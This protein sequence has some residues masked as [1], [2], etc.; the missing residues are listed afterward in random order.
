MESSEGFTIDCTQAWITLGPCG[1][2]DFIQL[3][4]EMGG[5]LKLQGARR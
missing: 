3:V 5:K 4:H 1:E 2:V